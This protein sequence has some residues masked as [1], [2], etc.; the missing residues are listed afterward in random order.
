MKLYTVG[1]VTRELRDRYNAPLEIWQVQ[2]VIKRMGI[3]VKRIGIY[4]VF[5]LGEIPLVE[6]ALIEAGYLAKKGKK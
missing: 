5:D 2:R 4:H 3:A 6:S 1:Q